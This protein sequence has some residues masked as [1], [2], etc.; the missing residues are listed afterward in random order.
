MLKFA[1]RRT[2]EYEQVL[3]NYSTAKLKKLNYFPE[4]SLILL[5]AS[6][7]TT[8]CSQNG[9]VVLKV[10]EKIKKPKRSHSKCLLNCYVRFRDE[11]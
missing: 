9:Q 1:V 2:M 11:H 3:S 10:H 8:L 4:G 7:W 5:L 6:N